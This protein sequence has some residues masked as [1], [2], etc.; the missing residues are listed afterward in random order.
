MTVPD[1]EALARWGFSVFPLRP[2]DKK[3]LGAWERFQKERAPLDL[4]ARWAKDSRRLNAAIATGAVSG[5]IVLDT[6]TAEADA[7]VQRRGVPRTPVVKTAKGRHYYFTHPGFTVR[8]FAGKLPGCDLRGDGGYVVA[9][10][11]THPSGFVYQWEASP[12]EVPFAPAPEWLLDL[13]RGKPAPSPA[14]LPRDGGRSAYAEKAL[15]GELGALRRASQGG[16]NDALNRAAFNLGQLVGADLLGQGEVERHLLATALAIGLTEKEA[17]ATL[18]SGLQKGKATPRVIPERRAR[19]AAVSPALVVGAGKPASVTSLADERSRRQ[20]VISGDAPVLAPID[21]ICW[22][23]QEVPERRWRVPGWIPDGVVTSIYA[24]GGVGKTLAAQQLMTSCATG[25]PWL[26]LPVEPCR[27]MGFFCEDSPEELH[28]RQV[29]ICEH[30]QIEL[31]DLENMRLFS[32]VGDDNLLMTFDADGTGRTTPLFDEL[33]EAAKSF[34]AQV[35]V[36]DTAADVFGG[37]ENIRNQVRQFIAALTRAARDINGSVVLL[38]H[39]SIDGMNKGHGFAGSTAWNNSVRSRLYLTRPP[40]DENAV[41]PEERLL[42]RAKANYAAVGEEVR[43]RWSD[44]ALV[45]IVP[46]TGV[47]AAIAK[48]RAEATFLACLEKLDAQGRH[49]SDS[50]HA[51]NFA[52]KTMRTMERAKGI[53]ERDLSQAMGRLFERGAIRVV[54]EGRNQTRKIVWGSG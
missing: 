10:E 8:N 34:G 32:R 52:P 51:Q 6:D 13:I 45:P 26:G 14:P 15:D 21:P 48:D 24:D 17:Q 31:G 35:L 27:A 22:Q 30:Y 50:S 5:V 3:P 28:R 47:F 49:V 36:I 37:N 11:C 29:A 54:K 44:G 7:E 1:W 2:R 53:S 43:M 25:K 40:D 4:V 46:E 20:R 23:G 39:P 19:E 38:A 41:D 18:A 16:R 12:D 9:A 42:T 33:V